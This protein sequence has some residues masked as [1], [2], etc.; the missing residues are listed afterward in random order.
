MMVPSARPSCS[1][2]VRHTAPG[3]AEIRLWRRCARLHPW[4][5]AGG[6]ERRWGPA[7]ECNIFGCMGFRFSSVIQ[8]SA[9]L[10]YTSRM[11]HLHDPARS[12]V[13]NAARENPVPAWRRIHRTSYS[14][15][16]KNGPW[17]CFGRA[18][19][20]PDFDGCGYALAG[21][22]E[23]QAR[24]RKIPAAFAAGFLPSDQNG[25]S[26]SSMNLPSSLSIC[27]A[28]LRKSTVSAM[29]SQP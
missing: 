2:R 18:D 19:G 20:C 9:R 28:R 22:Q 10:H 24:T 1:V 16:G 8:S 7:I 11:N 14:W 17:P 6:R 15:I 13:S 29:I 3:G 26:S 23:P 12:R 5:S 25:M 27:F 4:P 21:D